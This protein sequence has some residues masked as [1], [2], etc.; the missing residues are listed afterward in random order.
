[1]S[2]KNEIQVLRE[3]WKLYGGDLSGFHPASEE[4]DEI[5]MGIRHTRSLSR[6]QAYLVEVLVAI[7]KARRRRRVG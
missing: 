1:M 6:L 2:E 4:G 5:L 7:R 3:I